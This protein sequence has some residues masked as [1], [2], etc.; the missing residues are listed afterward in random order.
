[1]YLPDKYAQEGNANKGA[2]GSE[3]SFRLLSPQQ[4]FNAKKTNAYSHTCTQTHASTNIRTCEY[5][6]AH[7]RTCTRAHNTHPIRTKAIRSVDAALV[8]CGLS[9]D[10][11]QGIK[12]KLF[13]CFPVVQPKQGTG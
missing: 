12:L 10:W 8:G 7:T 9:I 2:T 11:K 13:G 4:N 3:H 6:Y 5:K 1:M